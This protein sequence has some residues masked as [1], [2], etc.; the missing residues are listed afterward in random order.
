MDAT[1]FVWIGMEYKLVVDELIW[2][3]QFFQ[4]QMIETSKIKRIRTNTN[5]PQSQ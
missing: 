1:L 3:M 2:Y 5:K 4:K